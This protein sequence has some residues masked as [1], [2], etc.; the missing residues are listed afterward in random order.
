M[1]E[2]ILIYIIIGVIYFL[3]N[4]L[5]KKGPEDQPEQERPGS[6]TSEYDKPKPMS[7]EDL[8]REI[9]EGKQ[10]QEERQQRPPEPVVPRATEY[11]R[12]EPKP[13]YVDYDDDLKD[14]E[15]SL[16]RV[17]FD[18]ER[19]NEVY[20]NAKKLAFNRPSLEESLTLAQVDTTYGK[21]KEFE[22]KEGSS[23]AAEYAKDL[24]NPGGF[25]KALILSEILN[26]RHF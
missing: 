26:R 3:F 14:E 21:F 2:K 6:D 5:K 8:L 23:K 17:S 18:Q 12:P 11:R 16:E 25:K 24:R 9:T 7:F 1:D 22:T 19:I 20:E 15:Q 4:R 10:Q 13:A